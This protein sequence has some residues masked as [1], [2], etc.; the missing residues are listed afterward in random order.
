MLVLVTGHSPEMLV[1]CPGTPPM[2]EGKCKLKAI[3]K[4]E[5]YTVGVTLVRSGQLKSLR[6]WKRERV[7]AVNHPNGLLL[8]S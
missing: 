7:T 4:E 3:V 8:F 6:M 2:G 5:E 1:S